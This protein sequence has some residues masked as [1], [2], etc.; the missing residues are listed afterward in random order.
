MCGICGIYG[1]NDKELVRKMNKTLDHRGPDGSGVYT[2]SEISLGHTRLAIIDISKSGQQPMSNENGTIWITYNGEVYNFSEL[3]LELQKKGHVFS[4][5]TDT[6]AI[7]HAYEEYGTDC[8]SR[9]NGMFAFALWDANKKILLLARDRLGI[10]P[11]FYMEQNGHVI[12]ASEQK[13]LLQYPGYIPAL[14]LDAMNNLLEYRYNN[15]DQTLFNGIRKLPPGHYMTISQK[16]LRINQYWDA[17]IRPKTADKK[18]AC[19]KLL[20]LIEDS[21]RYRMISDVPLGAYLSGGIDSSTVVG[22]MKRF[23]DSPRT[24]SVGFGE[25]GE[26]ELSYSRQVAEYFGTDHKEMIV[27]PESL[28]ELPKII[29]HLDEPM[30]DLATVPVYCMSEQAK[31]K[32]KVVLTGE[33][34]DEIW[35]GYPYYVQLRRLNR[36]GRFTG[37]IP[38]GLISWLPKVAAS[39]SSGFISTSL[40]KTGLYLNPKENLY[41]YSLVDN[42]AELYS[43]HTKK[44]I[45]H[46][47]AKK[48]VFEKYGYLKDMSLSRALYLDT[49][50]LLP[51]SYL[52]KADRM[53]MAHSIEGRVPLLDH[54]LVEFAFSVSENLKLKGRTEKYL[55]KESVKSLVPNAIYKRKKMG[56]SVPKFAW[57]KETKEIAA[58]LLDDSVTLRRGL[59]RKEYMRQLVGK[60]NYANERRSQLIWS[61]IALE[62]WNRIYIDGEDYNKITIL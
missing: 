21:V 36:I 35:A 34:N 58:R 43:P 4:S 48:E 39:I 53:T 41:K 20:K 55:F 37:Q 60:M 17:I 9:F 2:D 31:K 5:Q 33:G 10:K 25:F 8:L 62:I 18:E 45:K 14:N 24:F 30:A 32:V 51:N 44:G 50:T 19:A 23:S 16:G 22:M 40:R 13:A 11:L 26:D 38:K 54:R 52:A 27:Y 29:W 42:K 57:L 59:F 46:F 15:S 12:F 1:L 28:K 3:R 7:I 6:E 47:Y 49:K 56:F 61:F